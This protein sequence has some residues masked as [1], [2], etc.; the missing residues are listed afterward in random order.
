MKCQCCP[1]LETSNTNSRSIDG[2]LYEGNTGTS[3]VNQRRHSLSE[4]LQT[5]T[6]RALSNIEGIV[7]ENS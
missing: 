7:Y 4:V 6:L 1:H 2:F 5:R 3:W